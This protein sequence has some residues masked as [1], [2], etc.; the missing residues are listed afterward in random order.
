MKKE[1]TSKTALLSSAKTRSFRAGGYSVTAAVIVIAIAIVINILV[2]ALPTKYT[3]I[4]NTSGQIFTISDETEKLLGSLE[5]KIEI[6]WIV[7]SGQEDGTIS[8]LLDRYVSMSD[9]VSFTKKDP[10]VYPTFAQQYTSG[11]VYNNSLVVVCGER[12]RYVDYGDI[13][14]YDYSNYYTTGSYEVSF[15]GENALTSAIGYVV[16][17]ELP[18]LYVLTGHGE[19]T[20]SSDYQSAVQSAN[21]DTE[22]MSLLTAGEVPE[23]ADA[24]LIYAP[25]S[26]VSEKEL[27][28]LQD[29]L[30]GGGKLILITAPPQNGA[31]TNLDALM[32]DYGV[33]AVDGIV[34]EGNQNNYAWG[35]PYYLL[36]DIGSHDITS[37]LSSGGYYIL[38]PVA[39][40]LTVSDELPDGVS[41][42]QLLTSSGSS[43]SK[44][45][46]YSL[47]SY[48][49]EEGD[50][51][52]PFALAVAV[53][54]SSTG[55]GIVWVSSSALLDDQSNSQVSGANR[56]MFINSIS[57]L[58]GQEESI[59]IRAKSLSSDTLTV[60]SAAGSAYT[61]TVVGIL[62]LG[63][64]AVGMVVWIRRKRR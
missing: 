17:T 47:T 42:S 22:E 60:S 31:L 59:S 61:L 9:M 16:N 38:L 27:T 19:S 3:Q 10:D 41:V 35:T 26:D 46:G 33:T 54:D 28:M 13:Y 15:A 25:Q 53:T 20:L 34:V 11:T 18:K 6:Y 5:D 40:G 1:K 4:D 2:S 24:L 37:P 8:K 12:Y 21:I 58:C 45:A 51:D 14:Q 32:A 63:C 23:D 64:L 57:W 7:Q 43:F 49:K 39:Q 55:A 62:P 56:D 48:E 52:G 50:I 30:Q 44:A 29:F 36:P